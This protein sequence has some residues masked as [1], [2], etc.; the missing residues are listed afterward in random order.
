MYEEVVP[1][2]NKMLRT[3][4]QQHVAFTLPLDMEQQHPDLYHCVNSTP[5]QTDEGA[6]AETDSNG[7]I[8][9][10]RSGSRRY[11]GTTG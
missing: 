7:H 10:P 6:K 1:A 11:R 9:H 8:C 3:T 2:V 4:I 5:L